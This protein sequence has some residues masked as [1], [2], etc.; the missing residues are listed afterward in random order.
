MGLL[1]ESESNLDTSLFQKANETLQ[2]VKC[3]KLPHRIWSHDE[4]GKRQV[5]N[6]HPDILFHLQELHCSSFCFSVTFVSNIK[7]A[8]THL[9]CE[10]RPSWS[11]WEWCVPLPLTCKSIRPWQD[12]NPQSPEPKSDALSVMP[13]GHTCL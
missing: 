5:G 9:M 8:S 1:L 13:H 11:N 10:P 3:E 4:S 2:M 6:R 12:S 7:I